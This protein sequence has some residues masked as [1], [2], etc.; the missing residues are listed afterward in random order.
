MKTQEKLEKRKRRH[1][2]VRNKIVGT[3][4]RPRLVVF[5]STKHIYAQIID[6]S[7][8][9]TLVSASSAKLAKLKAEDKTGRKTVVAREVGRL[10][11]EAA[12]QQ[13]VQKVA[14]DRAGYLYHGRIAALADAAR[15]NGLEF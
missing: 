3:A 8:G 9:R 5:R 1:R 4:E 12:K 2:R 15:K 11:A 13:G 14:F 10:I 6:D 7:Q